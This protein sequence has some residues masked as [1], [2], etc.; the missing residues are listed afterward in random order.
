MPRPD[1]AI[2]KVLTDRIQDYNLIVASAAEP[3]THGYSK[4]KITVNRGTGGV[5][6]AFEPLFRLNGGTWIAHGRGSA[7]KEV[8]DE[9]NT[10]KMPPG[11]DEYSLKRLWV[12]KNN[13]K[14]WYYGF[15]SQALWPLFH[16]VFERPQFNLSDWQSYNSVNE[17]FADSI[18]EVAQASGQ[19]KPL[20]WV[21]DYQLA[22]VPQMLRQKNPDLAVA[23]FWHIPWPT[24]D[25]FKICPWDKEIIEGMLGSQLIGFQRH[26][27]CKNF[28]ASVAKTLEAKVDF[29]ALTVTYNNRVTYIRHFP[30]SI[31]YNTYSKYG[32]TKKSGKT[33]IKSTV[34][35]HYEYLSMGAERVEYTKGLLERMHGIDRFLEKYPEYIE[36]YMHINVLVPSRSYIEKYDRYNRE[37]MSLIENINFKYATANWQPIHVID[38][39]IDPATLSAFYHSANIMLVTSLADGM[40]LTAKEYIAAGPKDGMLILSDQAGA[41]D[42]LPEAVIIN[43]YDIEMIAD[44]IK[45]ALEMPKEERESRMQKMRET[46]Q[47]KTVFDWAAKFLNELVNITTHL[48]VSS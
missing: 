24:A 45:I 12:S 36:K 18:I 4:D 16:N 41:I 13:L 6:T 48:E 5:I 1:T 11:K 40:N 47:R 17:Q 3:Y 46:V 32:S 43:P 20:V 39:A 38:H 15:S 9:N 37:I 23:L 26:T 8:V 25:T 35:A 7:D 27:Y 31:D 44:S 19:K 34:S 33:F 30:I 2:K 29:D 22:L 10:I 14:G 42:E 28:L 21:Q